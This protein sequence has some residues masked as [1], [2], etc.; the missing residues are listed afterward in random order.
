MPTSDVHFVV[1]PDSLCKERGDDTTIRKIVKI[2]KSVVRTVQGQQIAPVQ[3]LGKGT[4]SV[5]P[6]IVEN[7]L[8][9]SA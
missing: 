9:F 6:Q 1:A 8:R 2:P 7:V 4:T 3:I 5:V